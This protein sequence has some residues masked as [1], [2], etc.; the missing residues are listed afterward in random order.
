MTTIIE[1]LPSGA[2]KPGP[3]LGAPEVTAFLTQFPTQDY[4]HLA[5]LT[6]EHVLQPDYD[7]ADEYEFGL[8]LILDGLEQL[9]PKP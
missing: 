8:A 6:I 7:Y 3:D 4:P 2:T 1:C 9:V 5:R